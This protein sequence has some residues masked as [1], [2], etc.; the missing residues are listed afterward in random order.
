MVREEIKRYEKSWNCKGNHGMVRNH[1][2]YGKSWNNV[3]IM[4]Q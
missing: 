2:L 1:G 4:K 3:E